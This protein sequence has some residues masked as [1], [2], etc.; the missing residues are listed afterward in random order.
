LSE[1]E[2]AAEES[3]P[4]VA[5]YRTVY[6]RHEAGRQFL[7]G[8]MAALTE[9]RQGIIICFF[10]LAVFIVGIVFI[11][12]G[13]TWSRLIGLLGVI[14]PIFVIVAGIRSGRLFLMRL[15]R[16]R[17]PGTRVESGFTHRGFWLQEEG[18]PT[19]QLFRSGVYRVSRVLLGYVILTP[20]DL[21]GQRPSVVSVR[22]FPRSR[23]AEFNAVPAGHGSE[24]RS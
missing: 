7:A 1:N 18:A 14:G 22:L 12:V 16:A 24:T 6:G 19:R 2:R 23:V 4:S 15:K 3:T 13:D 9:T 10:V 11:V 20:R 8:A 17:Q 21:A 5:E